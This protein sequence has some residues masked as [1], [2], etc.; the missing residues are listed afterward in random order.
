MGTQ[1][2]VFIKTTTKKD[3]KFY[4]QSFHDI[5]EDSFEE[6]EGEFVNA[7]DIKGVIEAKTA[8]EALEKFFE[9]YLSFEYKKENFIRDEFT[10]AFQTNVLADVDNIEVRDEKTINL[11]KEG[12][13][14]LYNE[15]ISVYIYEMRLI[16]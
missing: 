16:K 4:I 5:C 8:D 13:V 1:S 11:W 3:T 6:G 14:K 12:K 10:H 15:N 9:S 2:E 7:Y